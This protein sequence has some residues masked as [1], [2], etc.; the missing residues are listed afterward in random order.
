GAG[1]LRGVVT[2]ASGAVV[3]SALVT[4]RNDV[5]G[6]T[7]TAT[8]SAQ[9]IYSFQNVRAGNSM[10]TVTSPG[11]RTFQLSNVYLGNLRS[12]QIN[13]RLDVAS[14]SETV[15]VTANTPRLNTE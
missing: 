11:F 6:E 7:Q 4:V 15:E 3:P 1:S 10:I 2:D 12:N 5:T 13:A 8:T 14:A 9:G